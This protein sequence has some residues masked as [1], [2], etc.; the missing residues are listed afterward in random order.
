M[1]QVPVVTKQT[2][3][4]VTSCPGILKYAENC[5]LNKVSLQLHAVFQ[6][7]LQ[8]LHCKYSLHL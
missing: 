3:M 1:L 6:S 7:F 8:F 4:D 5:L 2:I